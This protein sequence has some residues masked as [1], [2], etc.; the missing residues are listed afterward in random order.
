MNHTGYQYTKDVD[1]SGM[2]QK[3]RQM[4]MTDKTLMQELLA[5][6]YPR[7]QMFDHESD[8]Y[9]YVTPLTTKVVEEFYKKKGWTESYDLAL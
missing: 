2:T 7:E 5:A 8:L 3:R 1:C 4:I 6:G 9:I